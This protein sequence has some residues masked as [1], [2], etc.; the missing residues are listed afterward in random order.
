MLVLLFIKIFKE[1]ERERKMERI[2][3][4]QQDIKIKF[5]TWDNYS[6]PSDNDDIDDIDDK[7]MSRKNKKNKKTKKMKNSPTTSFKECARLVMIQNGGGGDM[8]L[9]EIWI[10]MKESGFQT[11]GKTPQATLSSTLYT[12]IRKNG[13]QSYFTNVGIGVFQINKNL[14]KTYLN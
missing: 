3:Q 7:M 12:D 14:N 10:K 5:R 11:S 8:S 13:E 9:K 1:R 2:Q 4:Q 6:N